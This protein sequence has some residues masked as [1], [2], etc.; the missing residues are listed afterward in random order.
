MVTQDI[1]VGANT[2][3]CCFDTPKNAAWVDSA[4]QT[5]TYTCDYNSTGTNLTFA[6]SAVNLTRNTSQALNCNAVAVPC[7]T[8][9]FRSYSYFL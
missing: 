2:G 5:L 8:S 6:C 4:N 1:V 3:L 9:L 7:T